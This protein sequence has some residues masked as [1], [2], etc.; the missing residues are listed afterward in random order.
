MAKHGFSFKF[1]ILAISSLPFES[2]ISQELDRISTKV[3]IMTK[4]FKKLRCG[5]RFQEILCNFLYEV[6][7]QYTSYV[8]AA[9]CR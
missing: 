5:K 1:S 4:T 2:I 3:I 7:S 6:P 8:Y 9:R